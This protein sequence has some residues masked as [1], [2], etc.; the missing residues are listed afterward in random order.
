MNGESDMRSEGIDEKLLTRYLL[1]GLSD[2]EQVRVEDRAFTDA[3]YME[4]LDTAETDLIDAYV[5]GELADSER[6]AFEGRFFTSPQRRRK[7]EFAR[8]LA[9][10][11]ADF[12]SAD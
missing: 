3:G 12:K 1:G 11:S 5:R 8:A 4:A 6:R 9:T 10:V 7:V 2:E